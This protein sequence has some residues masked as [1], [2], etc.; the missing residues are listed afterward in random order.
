MKSEKIKALA[1]LSGGLDSTLAVKVVQEQGIEVYAINFISP[2]CR[3]TSKKR[4]CISEAKRVC[5][6]FGVKLKT[7]YVGKEYIEVIRNPKFGYGKNMNPCIDCRIFM[8]KI[9]GEYMKEIGAKFIITGEVL[10]QRPMS[11]RRDTINI[12]DRES[13]LKGLV[14]R[15]L[16]AR[17]F[18]ETIAEKEGWIDRDKLP[19]ITGRSRKKQMALAEEYGIN[20]YPCPAGGCLLTDASFARRLKDLFDNQRE[21]SMGD[22]NLL[23]VGRHLRIDK[24]TKLVIGRNEAEN[25]G[26]KNMLKDEDICFEPVNVQGPSAILR[27]NSSQKNIELAARLIAYYCK[28]NGDGITLSAKKHS[29]DKET[30]LQ[31]KPADSEEIDKYILR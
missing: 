30:F 9:A 28:G 31:T 17:Y 7:V 2:F 19:A 1:L 4:G 8:H 14:L 5:D 10:G 22:I 27:T 26:L 13:G 23:K 15:P 24:E 6:E 18:P 20:D 21:V 16:S 25:N 11:Q 29:E 12:I 3:C